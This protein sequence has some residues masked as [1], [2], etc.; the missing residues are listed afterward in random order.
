MSI[1]KISKEDIPN[2]S[3]EELQKLAFRLADKM[4]TNKVGLG[5]D[6]L[7]DTVMLM[8]YV[9]EGMDFEE[10]KQGIKDAVAEKISDMD[11]EGIFESVSGEMTT[12]KAQKG[13]GKDSEA[14]LKDTVKK[15]KDF[16]TTDEEKVIIPK[17]EAN[18]EEVEVVED[19]GQGGGMQDLTY[20]NNPGEAFKERQRKALEGDSTM[21][22]KVY[23]GEENGNTES[24]WGASD[25]E[26]GKKLVK[27]TKRRQE[28]I[29]KATPNI[30]SFGD[31]IELE[32]GQ[33]KP[34]EIAYESVAKPTIT[35]LTTEGTLGG[36]DRAKSII[37]EKHKRDGNVLIMTD[38]NETYKFKWNSEMNE[39]E[40]L[41]VSN[42]TKINEATDTFNKVLGFKST[43]AKNSKSDMKGMLD[44]AR[45]LV[46]ESTLADPDYT[47]FAIRKEDNKIIEAWNYSEYNKED[48]KNDKENLFYVDIEDLGLDLKKKDVKIVTKQFLIKNGM[49][50]EDSSNWRELS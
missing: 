30:L 34:R 8:D 28:K 39:A 18:E 33:T 43:V 41:S 20:D 7:P 36:V 48:I 45:K 15:I 38:G 14:Y 23:T 26:F 6:D 42:E 50:P 5:W 46:S 32:P 16:N 47:H 10:L 25:D 9:S 31:D 37:P 12:K 11:D 44:N 22:N 29:A 35:K 3:G 1:K 4:V 2:L 40:V 13:S 49:D 21:G 24:T 17:Y 27:R 19:I